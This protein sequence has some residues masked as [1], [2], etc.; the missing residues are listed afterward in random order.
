[1]HRFTCQLSCCA[2][3]LV[4]LITWNGNCNL[5][6]IGLQCV[7]FC[8][9]DELPIG[10][11]CSVNQLQVTE[12]F[13]CFA[14]LHV[15]GIVDSI[16]LVWILVI[17]RFSMNCCVPCMTRECDHGLHRP[18]LCIWLREIHSRC[19]CV[20]RWVAI[21]MVLTIYYFVFAMGWEVSY[22]STAAIQLVARMYCCRHL[23][24]CNC[25]WFGV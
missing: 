18:G 15:H 22:I 14:V 7:V 5:W 8:N 24:I 11:V 1:M 25:H 10:V 2:S 17:T 20:L 4:F 9:F 23:G 6:Q 12:V 21:R 19:L 16:L 3:R 13:T